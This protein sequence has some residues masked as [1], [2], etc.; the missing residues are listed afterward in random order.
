MVSEELLRPYL[1]RL[2]E[3]RLYISQ[4]IIEG[5]L[6][7]L[8]ELVNQLDHSDLPKTVRKEFRE[9]IE[10][11]FGEYGI[12]PSEESREQESSETDSTAETDASSAADRF[13]YGMV[14]KDGLFWDEAIREFKS[15]AEAGFHVAE[16]WQLCG[17]CATLLERFE[18]A[19][20]YYNVVYKDPT[21]SDELRRIILL[22]ITRCTQAQRK[23][24][25]KT[26]VCLPSEALAE[27]HGEGVP[28]GAKSELVTTALDSLDPCCTGSLIGQCIHSWRDETIGYLNGRARSYRVLNLLHVGT[29]SVVM[30][31][32][33][34]ETGKRLAGQSLTARFARDLLP[35]ALASWTQ[36]QMMLNSRYV[37]RVYDCA[38]SG[39]QLFIV[40]EYLP[41]SLADLLAAGKALPIPLAVFI[42]YRILEG[43]GDLHLHMG[44][45]HQIRSIFH[46][47]LRP[48]RV[49]LNIEKHTVKIFN[50]G[51]WRELEKARPQETAINRLPLPFL[52]Y[53]APEQFR[54][55]LARKKPPI[56]TDI[57]LFGVLFYEMLTGTPAF[58]AS[59][60]EEY[61]IQHCDQYPNPPKVWRPEIPDQLNELIMKCLES[62]PT[63]R[64][65]SATQ[66]SLFIEKP[67]H[68]YVRPP[69]GIALANLLEQA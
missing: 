57:Y 24:G 62:D 51:L 31:L 41:M 53:R 54:P 52:P 19:I 67:F 64:W 56:F 50:G 33:D 3:V 65:R 23:N 44:R 42:A 49:L 29:T 38:H 26:A 2:E 22:K 21:T 18:E 5:G 63:K 14:L 58:K 27:A 25:T 47:D 61:E 69:K 11:E 16:S 36:T 13:S 48:S 9:Q 12:I 6:A 46:L 66:I 10:A 45:D 68:L 55:Y 28:K 8:E 30:E 43:L 32:R 35:E 59:S 37:A 60:L 20:R 34:E 7:V 4:G 1:K 39:D 40:R 15:A 17:D